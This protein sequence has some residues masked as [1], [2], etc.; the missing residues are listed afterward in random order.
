[1]TFITTHR[2][3]IDP[4]LKRFIDEEV[5]PGT[6]LSSD[7]YWAGF[8]AIAHDLA[9]KNAALL[10][11]RDRL[12]T[13]LDDWHRA[14]AG[15][16]ADMPAYEAFLKEIGYL[17]APPAAF[18]ASTSNVDDELALQAGP[19]LV[20]PVMNAR[21]ALNAA[22][23]R[24]G[25]LYDALYG[26]DAIPESGGREKAGAYNPARGAAVI[27]FARQFLAPT[28]RPRPTACKAVACKSF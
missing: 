18:S 22:N 11:E 4:I 8:D 26:T 6:G 24:W 3:Q 19:Q 12:Q 9:P 20:V 1:M 17:V 7:A 16:I 23:A 28:H 13:L 10:A 2:L 21:Y 25:S 14:H 5:L 27:A 15:P